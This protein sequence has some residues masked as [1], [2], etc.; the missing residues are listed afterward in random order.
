[1]KSTSKVKGSLGGKPLFVKQLSVGEFEELQ[2]R[3]LKG[4]AGSD[5]LWLGYTPQSGGGGLPA[6]VFIYAT[7]EPEQDELPDIDTITLAARQNKGE[8]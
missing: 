4:N 6:H 7:E 8:W 1:M 5:W 2:E 3:T